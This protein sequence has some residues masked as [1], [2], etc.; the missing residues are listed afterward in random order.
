MTLAAHSFYNLDVVTC[1]F[2]LFPRVQL[3][4]R[5][6]RFQHVPEIR[7]QSLTNLRANHGT[8]FFRKWQVL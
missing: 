2:F 6:Y 7:K 3:Q 5:A 8:Q 1:D 4:L